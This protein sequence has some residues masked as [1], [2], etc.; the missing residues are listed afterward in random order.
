MVRSGVKSRSPPNVE[1]ADKA[2]SKLPL[3]GAPTKSCCLQSAGI[4]WGRPVLAQVTVKNCSER[5]DERTSAFAHRD[6]PPVPMREAIGDKSRQ[7][8][9]RRLYQWRG[10]CGV[11]ERHG[12]EIDLKLA[13]N[14]PD[15]IPAQP[16][17]SVEFNPTDRGEPS[18]FDFI[19]I[20]CGGRRVLHV[21]LRERA[22]R[23]R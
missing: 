9:R 17:V 7:P 12:F 3:S 13:H 19:P 16:I 1:L 2:G 15:R 8:D 10:V 23:A 6:P 21:A 11:S 18:R 4:A 5:A 20:S 14:M 22:D